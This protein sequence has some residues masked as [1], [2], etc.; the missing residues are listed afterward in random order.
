MENYM[1]GIYVI[2]C[3]SYIKARI[4]KIKT[5]KQSHIEEMS[6]LSENGI[7]ADL[8]SHS[9]TPDGYQM[10]LHM[11]SDGGL[12]CQQILD[13]LSRLPDGHVVVE[14]INC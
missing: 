3:E 8:S 12:I 10:F 9:P 11:Y 13:A 7:S 14:R 1:P 6:R 2:S 5:T 4:I